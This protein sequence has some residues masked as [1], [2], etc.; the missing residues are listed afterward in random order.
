MIK[1]ITSLILER[2]FFQILNIAK[3]YEL[4]FNESDLR[5]D[6]IILLGAILYCTNSMEISKVSSSFFSKKAINLKRKVLQRLTKLLD[7]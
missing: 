1:L 7:K 2:C 5:N 3:C 6:P 4:Y